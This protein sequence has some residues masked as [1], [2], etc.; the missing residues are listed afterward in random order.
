[1]TTCDFRGQ[2]KLGPSTD[3]IIMAASGHLVLDDL[4]K[5]VKEKIEDKFCSSLLHPSEILD[6]E[7]ALEKIVQIVEAV[8]CLDSSIR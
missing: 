7:K 6:V 1:M 3:Q 5:L 8:H 2:G 4:R